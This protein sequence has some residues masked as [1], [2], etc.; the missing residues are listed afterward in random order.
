VGKVKIRMPRI[1]DNHARLYEVFVDMELVER[2]A[3]TLNAIITSLFLKLGSRTRLGD[4]LHDLTAT[5]SA[6]V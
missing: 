4:G 5:R 3:V 6:I 2:L 1:L